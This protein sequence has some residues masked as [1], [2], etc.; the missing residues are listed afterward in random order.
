MHL[1]EVVKKLEGR[2]G[3]HTETRVVG[4]SRRFP[5]ACLNHCNGLNSGGVCCVCP[6][7]RMCRQ[8]V[9]ACVCV[10]V[11]V[12]AP[13]K[14][15]FSSLSLWQ[16]CTTLHPS[17]IASTSHIICVSAIKRNTETR[18]LG[19]HNRF[20]AYMLFIA[21]F[22]AFI[23]IEQSIREKGNYWRLTAKTPAAISVD[24]RADGQ[25]RKASRQSGRGRKPG[26]KLRR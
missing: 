5:Q 24:N 11:C 16:T 26:C 1:S 25:V 2:L 12:H 13:D 3:W 15:L 7:I 21:V 14:C 17:L 18:P 6:C 8:S 4:D 22:R 10:C 20:P 19:I 23:N 9:C